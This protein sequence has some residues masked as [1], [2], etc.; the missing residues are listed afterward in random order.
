MEREIKNTN[1]IFSYALTGSLLFVAAL[2]YTFSNFS[3]IITLELS[4]TALAF[5]LAVASVSLL[6][7]AVR[8]DKHR[9]RE[10]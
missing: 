4:N 8:D 3:N 10:V 7:K 6:I 9:M 5:V 1:S 2:A